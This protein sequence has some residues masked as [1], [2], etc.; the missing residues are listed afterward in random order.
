M[1]WVAN[2]SRLAAY[3]RASS[4]ASL[5]VH[6]VR[7]LESVALHGAELRYCPDVCPPLWT[8]SVGSGDYPLAMGSV[9]S[10]LRYVATGF[11][12]RPLG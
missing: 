9:C 3:S 11:Q 8:D 2:P 4:P 10:A 5:G 7:V 1:V 12:Q 6:P